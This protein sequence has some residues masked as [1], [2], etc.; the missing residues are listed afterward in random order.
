MIRLGGFAA[1]LG[2]RSSLRCR[3]VC[4]CCAAKLN[5]LLLLSGHPVKQDGGRIYPQKV[6]ITNHPWFL[7]YYSENTFLLCVYFKQCFLCSV[8]QQFADHGFYKIRLSSARLTC[9]RSDSLLIADSVK[10]FLSLRIS[11]AFDRPS[12]KCDSPEVDPHSSHRVS[13]L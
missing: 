9:T 13:T 11:S 7:I 1:G 5:E 2:C 3:D 10:K 4:G 8:V 12:R 6:F